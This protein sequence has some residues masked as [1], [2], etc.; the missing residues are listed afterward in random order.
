MND[1]VEF[2]EGS[3]SRPLEFMLANGNERIGILSVRLLNKDGSLQPSTYKFAGVFRALIGISGLRRLLP[4]SDKLFFLAKILGY[5]DGKSQYWNHNKTVDVDS[6]RGAYML[7][8]GT[9]MKEVGLWNEDGGEETEWHY[10]FHSKNWRVTFFSGV[11]VIHLKSMTVSTDPYAD[12]VCMNSF[13][14][15]F[16]KHENFWRYTALKSGCYAI[17]LFKLCFGGLMFSKKRVGVALEGL[18]IL[19]K[20]R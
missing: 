13:L 1:D 4:L 15:I 11:E 17:Y 19:H 6:F 3:I 8:R 12:L 18:R 16:K 5:G 10:R 7:V 2:L 20:P 14:I 9:A